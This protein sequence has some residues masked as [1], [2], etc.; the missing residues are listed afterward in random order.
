[1]PIRTCIVTGEKAEQSAFFRFT[2]QGNIL[3]PDRDKKNNGRGIYASKTT[4][5]LEKL[6]KLQK[7][8]IHF[9][10][11]KEK[12]IVIPSREELFPHCK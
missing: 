6:P 4:Q 9:L 10:R 8:I 1:M 11:T 5:S 2:L 7:K 12:D 3:V